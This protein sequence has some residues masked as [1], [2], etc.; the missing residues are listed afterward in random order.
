MLQVL[1]SAGRIVGL[2]DDRN[3]SLSR[4]SQQDV[5]RRP[6]VSFGDGRDDGVRQ[7]GGSDERLSVRNLEEGLYRQQELARVPVISSRKKTAFAPEVQT[8]S[9][10]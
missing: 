2:G 6:T 1:D 7:E 3:A 5:G 4:P 8:T 9:R 10:Q